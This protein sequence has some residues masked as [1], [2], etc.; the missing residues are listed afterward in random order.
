VSQH[1]SVE[2][3]DV[4]LLTFGMTEANNF[5]FFDMLFDNKDK[6]LQLVARLQ[7]EGENWNAFA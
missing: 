4:H 2:E 3:K 1:N 7:E 5:A 6:A